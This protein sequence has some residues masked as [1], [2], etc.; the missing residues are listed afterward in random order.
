MGF[1]SI[2]YP[3]LHLLVK[4]KDVAILIKIKQHLLCSRRM[5][6]VIEMGNISMF[7]S[8]S[9]LRTT[10]DSCM[11]AVDCERVKIACSGHIAL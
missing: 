9:R 6:W 10:Q 7:N 11:Y 2:F 1:L 4:V 3:N 8:C 5:G